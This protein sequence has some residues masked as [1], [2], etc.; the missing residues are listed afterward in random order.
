MC[1]VADPDRPAW[2]IGIEDPRAAGRVVAVVPVRDGAVATSGLAHRG[3]HVVDARTG[4]APT[5]LS[6]VT[7]VGSDLAAVDVEAT[8][9]LALDGAGEQWL[10][11][12]PNRS[13]VVVRADGTITTW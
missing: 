2:R 4:R 1:R 8:A 3:A 11:A 10:R 13:A 5:I 6:S 7:V 9:A 12:R